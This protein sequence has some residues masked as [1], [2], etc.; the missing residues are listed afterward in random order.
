VPGQR[1][2]GRPEAGLAQDRRMQAA[3]QVTELLQRTGQP[4]AYL[5]HI[6]RAGAPWSVRALPGQRRTLVP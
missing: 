4:V 1:A 2:D 3:G 5:V 6:G